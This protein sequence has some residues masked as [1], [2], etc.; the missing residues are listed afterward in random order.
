[1]KYICIVAYFPFGHNT[2]GICMIFLFLI[3][4]DLDGILVEGSKTALPNPNLDLY[5]KLLEQGVRLVFINGFYPE[6]SYI[7]SVIAD[8]YG[9]G[10][11]P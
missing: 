1:M 8:D 5:H 4:K 11:P 6:L 10:A 7:P 9:G 2:G 3:R